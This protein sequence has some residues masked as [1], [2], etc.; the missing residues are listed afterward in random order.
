MLIE[1]TNIVT[2]IY[3]VRNLVMVYMACY[4]AGTLSQRQHTSVRHTGH[5]HGHTLNTS[6]NSISMCLKF[7]SLVS[8]GRSPNRLGHPKDKCR[9]LSGHFRV[10]MQLFF[11]GWNYKIRKSWVQW[12]YDYYSTQDIKGRS[13]SPSLF[14]CLSLSLSFSCS[15]LSYSLSSINLC[16]GLKHHGT[17]CNIIEG[18]NEKIYV[19]TLTT[20]KGLFVL[21]SRKLE[22]NSHLLQ[23]V[24]YVLVFGKFT[25]SEFRITH[26]HA[27]LYIKCI[28]GLL[29]QSSS[30]EAVF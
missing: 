4:A 7:F 12:K 2:E 29:S 21:F 15:L 13:L 6:L 24:V 22:S 27:A 1:D 16:H 5:R 11:V 9:T 3:E 20:L 10:K 26:L 17:I 25:K 14:N 23:R 30:F 28:K 18:D 8:I 19:T